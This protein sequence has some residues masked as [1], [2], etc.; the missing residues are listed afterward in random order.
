MT[1]SHS[2]RI[3]SIQ[4]W[5]PRAKEGSFVGTDARPINLSASDILLT[6]RAKPEGKVRSESWITRPCHL[7]CNS[8]DETVVDVSIMDVKVSDTSASELQVP[9]LHLTTPREIVRSD[10]WMRSLIDLT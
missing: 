9:M 6:L 8:Q 10:S 3:A 5:V 7:C 4:L 2:L 1:R